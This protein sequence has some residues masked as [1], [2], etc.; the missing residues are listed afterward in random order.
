MDGIGSIEFDPNKEYGGC[1]SGDGFSSGKE[2][3]DAI[4]EDAKKTLPSGMAFSF[5][6]WTEGGKRKA[7]WVYNL[8]THR[9]QEKLFNPLSCELRT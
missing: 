5:I 8:Q 3:I 9:E 2:Y 4:I 7:G 6:S 1:I